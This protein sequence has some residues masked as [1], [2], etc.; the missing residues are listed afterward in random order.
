MFTTISNFN[1][2][3]LNMTFLLTLLSEQSWFYNLEVSFCTYII[4]NYRKTCNGPFVDILMPSV[5]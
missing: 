2:R 1:A 3:N 5:Q 4:N